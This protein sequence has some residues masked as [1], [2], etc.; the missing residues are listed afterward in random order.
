MVYEVPDGFLTLSYSSVV[1]PRGDDLHATDDVHKTFTDRAGT[2]TSEVSVNVV[3]G[4]VTN[5]LGLERQGTSNKYKY[6]GTLSGKPL[7]GEFETARGLASSLEQAALIRKGLL[8]PKVAEVE[9]DEYAASM[10]PSGP[11]HTVYRK[12]RADSPT[13]SAK[14]KVI[15]YTLVP[16]EA[17]WPKHIELP[18]GPVKMV[19]ERAWTHGSL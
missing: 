19:F 3:N 7:S 12:E 11:V 17:G 1:L 6:E 9:F 16:D 5:K 14:S 18:L 2:V 10:N 8:G 4:E 15:S 13:I